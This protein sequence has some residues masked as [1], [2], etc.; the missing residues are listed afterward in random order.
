MEEFSFWIRTWKSIDPGSVFNYIQH[1]ENSDDP[2]MDFLEKR[3]VDSV[4]DAGC[5]CGAFA[6]KLARRGF[7]VAGFD[8]SEDSVKLTKELLSKNG[9]TADCFKVSD[10]MS[11]DYKSGSFDAVVA[12]DVID[13]LSAKQGRDAVKELL[14]IT[15]PGGYILL[16][17]DKTDE[18]YESESHEINENGDYLFTSGK[19]AGMV[20]HPYSLSEIKTLTDKPDS[21]SLIREDDGFVVVIAK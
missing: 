21:V 5:G 14:R 13:H 12:R 4:C 8:I 1:I 3:G 2:I 10:I 7:S 16:S 19:W 17:L 11:T 6:L 18:E 20:F 15:K 9:Y